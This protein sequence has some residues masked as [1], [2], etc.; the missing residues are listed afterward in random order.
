MAFYTLRYYK[1]CIL[2]ML[3]AVFGFSST[4][5]NSL[6]PVTLVLGKP[7]TLRKSSGIFFQRI[8]V[9]RPAQRWKGAQHTKESSPR[10][11]PSSFCSSSQQYCTL[12]LRRKSYSRF[13]LHKFSRDRGCGHT[14]VHCYKK[15]TLSDRSMICLVRTVPCGV[16][17]AEYNHR[18]FNTRSMG[19]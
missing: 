5:V 11:S 1:W 14:I 19:F 18:T 8:S 7:T 2:L 3:G 16:R 4:A 17:C 10:S 12:R 6:G 9:W 13:Y 15:T